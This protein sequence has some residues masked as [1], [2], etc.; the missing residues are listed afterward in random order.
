MNSLRIASRSSGLAMAQ[1]KRIADALI[2][3]HPELAIDI[4]TVSTQG[5]QDRIS[6]LWKMTGKGVFTTQVEEALL[7]NKADIAVHSFKDLPSQS[8][9]GLVIA[10]VSERKFAEDV[11]VASQ[12]VASLLQ[13]KHGALIGSSSPRRIAQLK[14]FRPDLRTEPIRG[15]VETRLSKVSQGAYD[16]VVLAKAGLDRLNLTPEISFVFDPTE[17]I[18][19]PAQGALAVQCRQG[20]TQI[21][22]WLAQIH[23]R[24]TGVAVSAERKILAAL[25]PGCH[26]PIGAFARVRDSVMEIYAFVADL[27]GKRYIKETIQG[28]PSDSDTLAETVAKKLLAAGAA[29]ILE[30]F[31]NA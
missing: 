6:P 18:P 7:N 14:R 5:D 2:A 29:A 3:I 13:L 28:H 21:Q 1:T 22:N 26:V 11:L 16:A 12:P 8:T 27:D 25:H 17:F 4:I 31:E 19:A 24:P 23:H 10:A 9:P 20:D 15:N 30:E